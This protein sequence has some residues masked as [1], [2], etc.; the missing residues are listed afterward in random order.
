MPNLRATALRQ[1]A[2]LLEEDPVTFAGA[3]M[4]MIYD[5]IT[6]QGAALAIAHGAVTPGRCFSVFLAIARNDPVS[7][8]DLAEWHG[9]SHQLMRTRLAELEGLGLIKSQPSKADRR[10]VVL[11]LTAAGRAD[12]S[13][14]EVACAQAKLGLRQVFAEAGLDASALPRLAEALR[15]RPLSARGR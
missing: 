7:I 12:L 11:R 3:W 5:L 1:D 2:S 8:A 13:K 9:F 15:R 4:S 6:D 10:K 14:V